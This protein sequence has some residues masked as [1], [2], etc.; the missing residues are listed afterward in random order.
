MH[1]DVSAAKISIMKRSSILGLGLAASCA[2]VFYLGCGTDDGDNGDI[3]NP[4]GGAGGSAGTGGGETGGSA[5]EGGTGGG[6]A[7]T[8]GGTAGAG[9]GTAGTGGSTGGSAGWPDPDGGS[10]TGGGGIPDA[11]ADVNFN[12]DAPIHDGNVTQDSACATAVAE[13]EPLPLDIYLMLDRSGS[14]G[15]DCNVGATTASSWCYAI[16]ALAGFVS[17]S[18]SAGMRVALEFFSGDNCTP[19]TYAT[20]AVALGYLDGTSGGHASTIVTA[21][22]G[23]VPSGMTPTEAALLGIAQFTGANQATGRVMI[24]VLITDGLPTRCNTNTSHL[25]GVVASHLANTGIKTFVIGMASA[26]DFTV[27]ETIAAAGGAAPHNDFC[28]GATPCHHYDVGDGNPQAFIQA[29][30]QIQASAIAC[31]FKMPT[32]DAGVIDIDQV[33]VEYTPSSTGTPQLLTR[34]PDAASC[35]ADGWYYDD[36]TNPTTIH[37][38]PDMCATVQADSNAKVQVLLGCLGS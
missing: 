32:T 7:G 14:M 21:L 6:T 35:V 18:T 16:N 11:S 15:T 12:Y 36:N 20:P 22:N 8:G 9:G 5:G 4:G 25:A 1:A 26:L 34:V 19:S 27:I 23:A 37:L 10:G 31:Q 38:C 13:A 2:L 3:G 17:D 28:H 29:L 24:G 30:K 33:K